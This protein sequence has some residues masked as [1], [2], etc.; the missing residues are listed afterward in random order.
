MP[1]NHILINNS[2]EYIVRDSKM[3][4]LLQWLKDNAHTANTGLRKESDEIVTETI[5]YSQS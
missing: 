1:S 5:S 4:S 2:M 3:D